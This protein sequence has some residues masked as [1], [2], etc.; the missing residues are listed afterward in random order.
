MNARNNGGGENPDLVDLIRSCIVRRTNG[1]I[2]NL[3]VSLVNGAILIS[4]RT[5]R[6]YV[7]QLATSAVFDEMPIGFLELQNG[8]EVGQ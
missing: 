7:K 2:R 1:A 5:S 4:G 3:D 8:I 6:F